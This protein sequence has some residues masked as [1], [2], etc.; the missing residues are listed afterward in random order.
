M[1]ISNC[2]VKGL[3][4]FLILLKMFFL[5]SLNIRI[6]TLHFYLNTHFCIQY[7]IMLYH[8]IL[9]LSFYVLYTIVTM[10]T[11]VVLYTCLIK[12]KKREHCA[13]ITTSMLAV[14]VS[15]SDFILAYSQALTRTFSI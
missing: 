14:R 7:Y 2:R 3:A 6:F 4:F 1:E 13:S 11:L 12:G 5:Y 10:Y 15:M 9:I 8:Y